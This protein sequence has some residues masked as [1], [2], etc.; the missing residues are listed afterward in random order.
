MK[1]FGLGFSVAIALF[2]GSTV[3]AAIWNIFNHINNTLGKALGM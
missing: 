3:G 2:V 1:L